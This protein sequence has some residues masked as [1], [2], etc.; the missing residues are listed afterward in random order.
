MR[1]TK[2]SCKHGLTWYRDCLQCLS[3]SESVRETPKSL[4]EWAIAYWLVLESIDIATAIQRIES[5]KAYASVSASFRSF[6]RA[7]PESARQLV[8]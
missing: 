1:K 6:Q 5:V 2:A 7:N 8:M 3:E 4:R